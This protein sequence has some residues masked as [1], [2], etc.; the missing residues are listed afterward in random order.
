MINLNKLY[1]FYVVANEGSVKAA[2]ALLNLTQPTISGQIR[3]LEEDLGFEL[4]VREHRRL[5][6]NRNGKF[7]LKKAKQIFSTVDDLQESLPRRGFAPRNKFTIGAIQSLSNSF[8]HDFSLKLWRDESVELSITQGNIRDLT[9][10]LD[11]NEIDILLSDGPLTKG[12]RYRSINLG[13]DRLFAVAATREYF[14][15]GSFPEILNQ[16]SYLAFSNQGR[17]QQDLNFYFESNEIAP[18]YVGEVD[19]VT[20]MRVAT[21]NG[22]FFSILPARAVRE[23]LKLKNLVKLGEVPL[24]YSVWATTSALSANKKQIKRLINEYFVRQFN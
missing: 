23:S 22:R 24:Q 9:Q 16:Q 13:S 21:E 2:S 19:D 20:L 3:Q 15:R 14:P 1:Y 5:T 17:L 8:L 18:D 11:K 4:F 7:V 12:K 10:R 6:L